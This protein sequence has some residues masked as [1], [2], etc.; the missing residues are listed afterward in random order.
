MSTNLP[1]AVDAQ[2]LLSYNEL[3]VRVLLIP[4]ICI[5][6]HSAAITLEGPPITIKELAQLPITI[7]TMFNYAQGLVTSPIWKLWMQKRDRGA[8]Q[9][10]GEEACGVEFQIPDR[11]FSI[12]QRPASGP[13]H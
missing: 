6:Q 10:P 7:Q 2:V 13:P 12:L 1:Y 11:W 4:S 9:Q 5:T 3:K 8:W